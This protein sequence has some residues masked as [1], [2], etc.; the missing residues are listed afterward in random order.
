MKINEK[1]W[2]INRKSCD[3]LC[4]SLMSTP[5]GDARELPGRL[6]ARGGAGAARGLLR[7]P[8]G[9]G[10]AEALGGA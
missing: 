4:V 6:G 2:E 8:R 7:A 3:F 5:R 9:G 1:S 10:A